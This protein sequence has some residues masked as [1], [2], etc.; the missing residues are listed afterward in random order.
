MMEWLKVYAWFMLLGVSM[1]A[2][3]LAFIWGLE[4]LI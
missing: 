4:H 3:M 2:L 1:V